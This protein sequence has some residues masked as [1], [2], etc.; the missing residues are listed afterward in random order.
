MGGL[1]LYKEF[2]LGGLLLGLGAYGKGTVDAE[3]F[4]L[5]SLR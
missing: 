2:D 4:V 5:V 1:R 3:I